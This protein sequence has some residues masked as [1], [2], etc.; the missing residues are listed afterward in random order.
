VDNLFVFVLIM[1]RFDVP[2]VAQERV[3]LI[4]I[5][6]S[7]VLRAA[8]IVAGTAL[9]SAASWTFCVFG[10][11]LIYTAW[12]LISGDD[13]DEEEFNEYGPVRLLRRVLPLAEHY[14]GAKLR[15]LVEGRLLWTPLV[16]SIAAIA[17]AN[18]IFALDSMPAIFGLT[19][20]TFI[21][22]A[23]NCFAL[24]GLR[25]LF[26][27]IDGLLD[28]LVYLNIGLAAIL[29]FIGF[30]L[31]DEGLIESH[32]EQI[33]SVQ[34]PEIGIGPSLTFITV[35]LLVAAVASAVKTSR[36][37]ATSSPDGP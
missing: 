27:L 26:F 23:A 33:G 32:V 8:F 3:L 7:L 10:V 4:G 18:F 24:L 36:T 9:V 11:L 29:A 15:T 5:L 34:L 2:G 30:K 28:R 25:Q 31:V 17:L 12:K 6:L 1:S 16:L 14:D 35:V 20:D 22:L 37:P 19:Q 21:I 13:E